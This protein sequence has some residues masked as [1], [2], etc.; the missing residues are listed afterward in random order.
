MRKAILLLLFSTTCLLSYSQ[1]KKSKG[2]ETSNYTENDSLPPPVKDSK[3]GKSRKAPTKTEYI[4]VGDEA[5]VADTATKFTGIIKYRMTS[6][7]PSDKDSM[8]IIFG[9]NQIRVSMFTPGYREDQIFETISIARFSDSTLLLLDP[10][11]KTYKVE[12]LEARNA[13]TEFT[14]LNHKKTM[15]IMGFTCPEYSGEMLLKDGESY[16]A[17]ALISKQHSYLGAVDYNLFNI[18][19]VVYGYRIVL[20]WRTKSPENENT[21]IIAYKIEKGNVE[22]YFDLTGYKAK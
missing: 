7:D 11:T 17:A 16:E 13:G 22:S 9:E 12:R 3:K 5:P 18:Q 1:K 19:P 20:G 10:R 14:L 4:S 21:Y 6:D 8:I 2:K 15:N